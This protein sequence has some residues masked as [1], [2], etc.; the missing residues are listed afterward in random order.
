MGFLLPIGSHISELIN[1]YLHLSSTY[2]ILAMQC[3]KKRRHAHE[4]Y[5]T[6]VTGSFLGKRPLHG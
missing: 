2:S 4:P 5:L 1:P 6:E 3:S